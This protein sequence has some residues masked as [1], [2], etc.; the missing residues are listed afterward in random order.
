MGV[1]ADRLPTLGAF[2]QLLVDNRASHIEPLPD[3]STTVPGTGWTWRS[4][5]AMPGR[6][7]RNRLLES[8]A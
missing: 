3:D 6:R 7:V 8:A 1:Y 5:R 2:S 4:I